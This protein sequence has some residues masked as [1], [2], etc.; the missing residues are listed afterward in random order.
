MPSRDLRDP[1]TIAITAGR[2]EHAP[3]SPIAV[4]PVLSAVYRAGGATD[5]AR[6]GNPTWSAL[7][8]VLGALEG[9]R[10]LVF[11]SGIAAIAAVLESLPVGARVVAPEDSYTGLRAL[12]A[13]L[14]GRGRLTARLVD[15]A[16]TPAVAAAVTTAHLLWVESPTNPLLAVADL[17]A[18]VAAARSAGVTTVV[19]NTFATPLLQRPLDL[20]VDVV[21]HSATKLLS[22]HSD[23]LCGVAVTRDEQW[24]TAL[25][26]RRR[27]HGAILGP[28]EAWLVLRGLRTL[29]LRLERAQANAGDLAQR[30]ATHPEVV[31][32]RYPGLPDDPGH[33]RAASQLQGFGTI[34]SFEVVDAER[35]DRV[36]AAVE[37][38][39]HVTSLGGVETTMERRNRQPGEEAV[40]PGLIRLSVG[41]E[42]VDD[43]WDDLEQALRDHG[44]AR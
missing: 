1:T 37:L 24:Y 23:V 6:T 44:R 10:S 5:Y 28:M 33:E 9:G 7:E 3:G 18:L 42:H 27:L 2:G 13:D 16:D 32:V 19:D 38:I 4:P 22:G 26:T 21:V 30:L 20:D 39:E 25:S 40:P 41:C 12:L 43:L 29:P 31:R 17:P 36:C 14:E 35:A 8:E 34:V 15:I 11:S